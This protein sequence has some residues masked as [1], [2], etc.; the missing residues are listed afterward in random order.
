MKSKEV[1]GRLYEVKKCEAECPLA[2]EFTFTPSISKRVSPQRSVLSVRKPLQVEKP[3]FHP[4]INPESRI[5]AVFFASNP[6]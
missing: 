4:T 2:D 6:A 3:A 1:V 5:L